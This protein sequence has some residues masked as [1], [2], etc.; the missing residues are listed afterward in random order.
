MTY[1]QSFAVI[2]IAQIFFLFVILKMSRDKEIVSKIIPS[3]LIGL[4]FGVCFD[5]IFGYYLNIFN[6]NI[7]FNILFLVLNGI[8]SYGVM[9]IT[10][11]L[12]LGNSFWKF[13]FQMMTLGIFYEVGNYVFPVWSWHFT[14]NFIINEIILILCAYFGLAFLIS[15]LIKFAQKFFN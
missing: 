9:V 4:V 3:A 8:F 6:Y 13:Y 2:I 12:C 5:L 15:L 14:D 1:W 10:V 11:W 7:G